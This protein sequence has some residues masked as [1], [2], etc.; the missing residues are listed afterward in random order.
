MARKPR[1]HFTGALYHVMCRGNQGQS[2][3]KE[4]Q[5][6]ERY[7]GFLKEG[8]KR[9]GYRLYAYVLMGNHVH[10]LIEIGQTALLK[11]MQS[12]LFC[13][14]R[15]WNR[16]YKKT[17]HLFQGRYKAIL[18]DKESYLLELIRY[19]HLNPVRSKIVDDPG[20]YAWS[21]HGAY[22]KGEAKS[23]IALDEVLPHWGKGRAQAIAGYRRFV[24]EGLTDGHRD[25]L[26]KV[27]DQRYLGDNA[28]VERVE[29]REPE[30]EERQIVE[31][32][33]AK[34]KD[35]V[36]KQFGLPASAVLHRGRA[37]EIVRVRRV[38]AWVG[39]ELGGFTNQTLAKELQQE[40]AILSRGLGKL[41]EELASEPELRGVV[42]TL[43]DNLSKGRRLKRSIR[44][45]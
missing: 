17:G 28:F 9:F 24:L 27:I 39:R 38:M 1:V 13:Y 42:E 11:V 2:I 10:H 21:S 40:P 41:A 16:R 20:D 25:D 19:L 30:R 37:R 23:W 22:L 45:A 5:D 8:Q 43:C 29:Q 4:D 35:R 6:R 26:Y 44:F 32:S 18:C 36:C 31:I 12:M 3:F 15:Y 34:I 33:W 7:L 14:T